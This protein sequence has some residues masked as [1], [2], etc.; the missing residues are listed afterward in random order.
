MTLRYIFIIL[1]FGFYVQLPGQM[2]RVFYQ[3][4]AGI[5][6]QQSEEMV[7]NPAYVDSVGLYCKKVWMTSNWLFYS[8]IETNHEPKEFLQFDFVQRI[9]KVEFMQ[10]ASLLSIPE[11][12][13]DS[14]DP[15]IFDKHRQWQLDTLGAAYFKQQGVD[16]KGI[17]IA[18]I[19]AGFT[20]ANESKA[21]KDIFESGRVLHTWDFIDN[22]TT[23]FD[24]SSH[25]T[26]VWSCIAGNMEGKPTGLATG[27]SFI[28]LRSE[29][30]KTETMADE[31]RWIQAIEKAYTWGADMV[32]SSVGFTNLLHSRDQ[33]NGQTLISQAA[34]LAAQKGMLVVVSAGNEWLTNWKTI[35]IPADAPGVICVGGI[36]KEGNHSYFSSVGPTADGR[37]KPDVVAP[38]T[39]VVV[40]G[41]EFVMSNGTSFA[42]PLVAG[43][44]ACMLQLKGKN[45]FNNDSLRLYGGLYP[46]FDYVYGYGVPHPIKMG[47]VPA[48]SYDLRLNKKSWKL[49]PSSAENEYVSYDFSNVRLKIIGEDGRIKFSKFFPFIKKGLFKISTTQKKT[50]FVYSKY[51]HPQATDRWCILWDGRYFE[52]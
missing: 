30:Q 25:G 31:D 23:V 45:Q 15:K 8:L 9:E 18:V 3:P 6:D 49:Y 24:G 32:S 39:C 27:A 1:S 38:G 29:D 26:G 21:F 16:G 14:V 51:Y 34:D 17:V 40:N 36:D 22:D 19:D 42:A 52:F 47:A 2:Y 4:G 28:L 46:Y 11:N 37:P 35:S 48:Y 50:P 10:Q 44:W 5:M 41:N 33:V 13:K 20:K 12:E 43:F 7:V